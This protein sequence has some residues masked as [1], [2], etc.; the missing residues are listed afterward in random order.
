QSRRHHRARR[1][2]A[3]VPSASSRRCRPFPT[4][5]SPAP[6]GARRNQAKTNRFSPE[7]QTLHSPSFLNQIVRVRHQSQIEPP[8]GPSKGPASSDQQG[9]SAEFSAGV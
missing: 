1:S 7:F 9:D 6:T 5:L 8:E 4:D 2:T 3:L